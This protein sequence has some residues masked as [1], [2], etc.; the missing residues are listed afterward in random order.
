MEL[1][2]RVLP[3]RRFV[4]TY[5]LYVHL[6]RRAL[7]SG[8]LHGMRLAKRSFA[9]NA[10]SCDMQSSAL[11]GLRLLTKLTKLR[12][13]PAL[14]AK[15]SKAKHPRRVCT[16]SVALQ[17][18]ALRTKLVQTGGDAPEVQRKLCKKVKRQIRGF[19][20]R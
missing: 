6:L 5:N 19:T 4:R 17:S 12:F 2:T 11:Q 18:Y 1:S 13:V 14:Y 9:W 7:Q 10:P 15:Q 3:N 16:Q 8:A 20:N